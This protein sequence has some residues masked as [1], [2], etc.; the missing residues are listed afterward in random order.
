MVP[1]KIAYTCICHLSA[2]DVHCMQYIFLWIHL[3][4]SFNG[5]VVLLETMTST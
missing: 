5:L 2:C 1:L 3:V 4:L